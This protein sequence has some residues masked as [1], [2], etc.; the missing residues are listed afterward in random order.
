MQHIEESAA[1]GDMLIQRGRWDLI[2]LGA[3][4]KAEA[5]LWFPHVD[6]LDEEHAALECCMPDAADGFFG[7]SCFH[8]IGKSDG[9]APGGSKFSWADSGNT[10]DIPPDGGRR[11][12]NVNDALDAAQIPLRKKLWFERA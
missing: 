10:L 8:R 4:G 12:L 5:A 11:R 9:V 1:Y 6:G 7:Q 3:N 2:G